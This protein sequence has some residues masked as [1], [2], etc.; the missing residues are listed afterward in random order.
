MKAC[1]FS[2][3]LNYAAES[4]WCRQCKKRLHPFKQMTSLYQTSSVRH[5]YLVLWL[6]GFI[7]AQSFCLLIHFFAL[8]IP[9]SVVGSVTARVLR[10]PKIPPPQQVAPHWTGLWVWRFVGKV[11]GSKYTMLKRAIN[12]KSRPTCVLMTVKKIDKGVVIF[13][14]WLASVKSVCVVT[15]RSCFKVDCSCHSTAQSKSVAVFQHSSNAF[16]S[17]KPTFYGFLVSSNWIKMVHM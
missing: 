15:H 2:D 16:L 3:S 13:Q 7:L 17:N 1:L 5:A 11:K 12:H 14:P 6:H 8:L 10:A 9:A 4:V